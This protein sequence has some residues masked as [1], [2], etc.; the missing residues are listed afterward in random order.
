MSGVAAAEHLVASEIVRVGMI[1]KICNR[2]L[3]GPCIPDDWSVLRPLY[4]WK[5]DIRNCWG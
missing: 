4:K 3:Y 5:G 2:V 1:T